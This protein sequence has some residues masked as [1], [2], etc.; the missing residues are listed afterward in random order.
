MKE[1]TIIHKTFT[2]DVPDDYLSQERTLGKTGTWTYDGPDKIWILVNRSDNTIHS[3]KD[4]LEDGADYPAPAD[5]YK[6]EINCNDEPLLATIVG[7]DQIR[8][9]NLLDQYEEIMPDGNVYS[10]PLVPPPDHTYELS[11]ITYNLGLGKFD[12]PFPWKK[13]HIDWEELRATRS[14]A[15]LAS[16]YKELDDMP[17]K[18]REQWETYRQALRDLPQTFGASSGE[19]PSV[20]PWK[21][22]LPSEPGAVTGQAPA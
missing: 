1:N 9:Y 10:R 18:V 4:D 5:M 16:D 17:A 22:V 2:Y 19:T 21:V 7:A 8:D 15:L 3:W 20:D 11:E 14:L 13:P 6:V 12:T